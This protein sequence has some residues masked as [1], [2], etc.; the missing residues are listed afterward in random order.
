[1]TGRGSQMTGR[2]ISDDKGGDLR[3]QGGGSQMTREGDI[4]W[5]GS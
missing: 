3:R 4:R 2:G 5:P 1:M